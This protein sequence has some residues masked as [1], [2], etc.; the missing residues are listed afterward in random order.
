MSSNA[1]SIRACQLH[2]SFYDKASR[3][4]IE[5]LKAVE[6]DFGRYGSPGSRW[7]V[8]ASWASA[9]C[10]MRIASRNFL[11]FKLKDFDASIRA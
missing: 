11:R 4:R 6:R 2:K 9:S 10:V 8:P 1:P 7:L 5:A 3:T